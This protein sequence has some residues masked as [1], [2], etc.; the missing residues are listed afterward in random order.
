M[1]VRE[2]LFKVLA[3]HIGDGNMQSNRSSPNDAYLT[4]FRQK[5][6]G[7]TAQTVVARKTSRL[8]ID[9][10]PGGACSLFSVQCSGAVIHFGLICR[11]SVVCSAVSCL[12]VPIFGTDDLLLLEYQPLNWEH[13]TEKCGDLA[14]AAATST[15]SAA[16]STPSTTS[17]TPTAT[18]TATSGTSP[19]TG[20]A[21]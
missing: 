9:L 1:F 3:F 6:R 2:R 20:N 16:T 21:I 8:R 5:P 10:A 14:L 11:V 4:E 19:T 13:Q 12:F 7:N 18:S 17:A 15:T